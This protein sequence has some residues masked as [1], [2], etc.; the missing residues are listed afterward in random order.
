MLCKVCESLTGKKLFSPGPVIYN[1]KYWIVDHAYPTTISGWIV[2]VLKRHAEALH[3]L[4]PDEINE[5]NLIQTISIKIIHETFRSKKEYLGCFSETERH[6][7][8]HIIPKPKSLA[9]EYRVIES[10]HF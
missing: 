6:L 10:S 2:I 9:Y 3:E 1:G 7:H 4:I 5:L 8:I